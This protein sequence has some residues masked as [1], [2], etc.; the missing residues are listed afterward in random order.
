L[1]QVGIFRLMDMAGLF[2]EEQAYD[3]YLRHIAPRLE[4]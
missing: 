3:A 1:H 4:S 2:S